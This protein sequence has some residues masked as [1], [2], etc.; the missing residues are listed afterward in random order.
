MPTRPSLDS[1]AARRV[2]RPD[3]GGG[4]A[5]P[6][7]RAAAAR[8]RRPQLRAVPAAGA[9]RARL[10]D[11]QRADD[12]PGRRRRLQ[13]QRADLPGGPAGEG[14]SGHARARRPTT[15]AASPSRSPTPA[16]TWCAAVLP[17]HIEVLRQ[18]LFEPLSRTGTSGRWPTARRRCATTC[19]P[20]RPARRGPAA[21]A[22]DHSPVSTSSVASSSA[23]PLLGA[24]AEPAAAPER[25]EHEHGLEEQPDEA[26]R[27]RCRGRTRRCPR[28]T[29]RC[30]PGR[31]R[32]RRPRAARRSCGGASA[33]RRTPRP[34]RSRRRRSRRTV[35][36]SSS[37]NQSGTCAWN[38]WRCVVRC[39]TPAPTIAEPS[40]TRPRVWAFMAAS[41]RRAAAGR[42]G[43]SARRGRARRLI[44]RIRST[45]TSD[46]YAA[47]AARLRPAEAVLGADASRRR[48]R[49]SRRS[50]STRSAA[51]ARRSSS[52]RRRAR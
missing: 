40:R 6:R 29:A 41:P 1:V 33:A 49:R 25:A 14:R 28:R 30:C 18:Q 34:G 46:L 17:G 48:R 36:S 9:P 27:G 35:R 50:P 19:G 7:R 13:P 32:R 23:A 12:R 42:P 24:P 37:G 3:G 21:G 4:P 52:P 16:A 43:S 20:R 38:S 26:G 39:S 51:A 5:A 44:A 8:G 10:A 47:A 45:S 11:G 2:L 22:D 15:S 31:S